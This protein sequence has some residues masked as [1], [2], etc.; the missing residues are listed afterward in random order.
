M[1]GVPIRGWYTVQD[2]ASGDHR[3]KVSALNLGSDILQGGAD[4]RMLAS[5]A[6]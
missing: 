1:D 2:E 4:R 5:W 3:G 6:L